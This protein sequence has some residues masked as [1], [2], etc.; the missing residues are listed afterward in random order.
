LPRITSKYTELLITEQFEIL[1]NELDSWQQN[2][3]Q[4]DDITFIGLKFI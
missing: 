1:N 4:R 2:T 3:E